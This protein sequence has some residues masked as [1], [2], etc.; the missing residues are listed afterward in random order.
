MK[1]L[2][3]II[4]VNFILISLTFSQNVNP[5]PVITLSGHKGGLISIDELLKDNFLVVND[6]N[7]KIISFW[8][9]ATIDGFTEEYNSDS[10]ILTAN[11]IALIKQVQPMNKV[12]I[13]DIVVSYNGVKVKAKPINFKIDGP[14]ASLLKTDDY[15]INT[16]RNMLKNPFI[17]AYP[18]F[19][20]DDKSAIKVISFNLSCTQNDYY[21]EYSSYSNELTQE[22]KDFVK[23][24]THS[25]SIINIKAVDSDNDTLN[26]KSID[27]K[28]QNAIFRSKESILKSET[29]DFLAPSCQFDIKS[30]RISLIN[31]SDL[32]SSNNYY[33]KEMKNYMKNIK[34]N[35]FIYF[36]LD[37]VDKNGEHKSLWLNIFITE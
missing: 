4:L 21:Y 1:K 25:F 36:Y 2:V 9:A 15:K 13:E 28:T 6:N 16:K 24:A 29:I 20:S 18:Y 10:N 33:T 19:K 23:N 14:Y 7:G 11:Q 17:Y 26:L 37:V 5:H 22:M 35:T 3:S 34:P 31:D 32:K 8:V 12:Y 27:I 30:F